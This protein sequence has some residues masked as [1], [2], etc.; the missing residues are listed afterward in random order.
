MPLVAASGVSMHFTG[1]LILEGV[2]VKIERGERI[3]LIGR[4]GSGKTT[5]LRILAGLLEPTAGSVVRQK[6]A[7]VAYQ[8]QELTYTPGATV[9]EELR[10]VFAAEAEREA[11]LRE[12]E[13][14]LAE[15]PGERR[16]LS[17]YER[18][19]G[20][21]IHDA[22]RRIEMLLGSLGLPEEAWHQPIESFSGGE[23]NVLG[24]ARVLLEE[25]E[26]MLLDEPSNHLDMEGVEWFIDFLRR[27]GAAVVMVS[28]DRHLLDESVDRIWELE[29]R[30]I[31]PWTGNYSAFRKQKEE[32][33]ALQ[34][35]RIKDMANA[36]D[37]PAQAKRAKAMLR[38]IERMEK[39]EKPDERKRRFAAA[40]RSESR[41]G[42]IALRV[43]DFHFAHGD[44]VLFDGAD[45]EIDY[46][47][48]VCLVGPNGSGKTTLMRHILDQGGW[49]NETLRLGKAV[50][51]GEYRQ[52]HDAL[53]P[54]ATLQEWMSAVTGLPL[55]SAAGLLHRFFFT[56][57]DLDRPIATLSGGEKSR[58]Q[59]ARLVHDQVNF[60]LLDE[61][62]NH[63]DLEACEQ[64]EEMLEAFDGTLL[65]ISH[66][67]YFLDRLVNRV[68][69]VTDR[70]LVDHRGAF[71]EWWRKRGPRQRKSA[72]EDRARRADKADAKR[73]YEDRK[74]RQR[75]FNRL[76]ARLGRL[77]QSIHDLEARQSDL[78]RRL[79][80]IYASGERPWEAETLN[81][82]FDSVR[83]ELTSLY[84]EWEEL[85]SALEE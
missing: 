29:R 35:R 58:L 16:Y 13:A 49:E 53:N 59:L 36:Y 21:G 20:R 31:T 22:D 40:L 12:L 51:A 50:K 83:G 18:L 30:T 62:T 69:E 54:K 80:E 47:E 65:V 42:R 7:A 84:R 73:E 57:D 52:L 5:L 71:D 11:R 82:D 64:L 26:V 24:L 8:A 41:H 66:D 46:G 14:L 74:E 37:D 28:H 6:G 77:E 72:L 48:R 70:K 63:L 25:P 3:G 38:R 34:A 56:R 4:N 75:E 17:E 27:T 2:G 76:R 32:G 45:L 19:E 10:A 85:S 61:P 60:L 55:N 9:H 68:V 23:R 78:K 44:R 43:H 39:V 81:R 67:R 33:L 1:P 15:H 79:E